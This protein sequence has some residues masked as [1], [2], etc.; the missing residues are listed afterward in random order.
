MKNLFLFLLLICTSVKVTGQNNNIPVNIGHAD[1]LHSAILDE[2]RTLWI[3]TP[4]IDTSYFSKSNYPV[5]YVLD[6]D[7][8]FLSLMAMVQQ[9]GVI[10]GNT[11]FPEMII[12]GILN[13]NGNRIRDLTPSKSS[14]FTNSGGG[15]NFTLFL[16]NELIPYM[17]KNYPTAP[18]RTLAGHSL[19]GLMVMNTLLKH[20]SLFNAYIAIDPSMSYDNGKLLMQSGNILKQKEFNRISLFLGIA[21]TMKPGMDT[22]YVRKDTTQLTYHIRSIL[23]LRDNLN[24]TKSNLRWNSKYYPDDN[25]AS[26]P[27]LSAYDGLRYIFRNN[28]FP[29]NQ[30]VNQFFDKKYSA[31]TI[32]KMIESHYKF[33]SNERGYQVRPSEMNIN[34]LGYIFLQQK[35]YER[36]E[37]FFKI[38]IA[39]YPNSFNVYDSI[40]DYYLSKGEKLLAV[41]YFKKAL[42]LKYR[43]DIKM[44]LDKSALNR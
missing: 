12:V 29:D 5:L 15:E 16:K 1:T 41:K 3:Y 36:A 21:N 32:K 31:L 4:A 24:D 14:L 44:K 43:S 30:P 20:T 25:H 18:Y 42:A 34:N 28:K 23:K 13:S 6:G 2:N 11:I 37:M 22:A 26:I 27:L 9:L 19:G 7:S 39:Y 40:G 17:D 35:D 38:N 8:Y 33:L 10:N